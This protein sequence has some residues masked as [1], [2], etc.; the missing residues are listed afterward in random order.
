MSDK[1]AETDQSSRPEPEPV[2][3]QLRRR[4]EAALR[5]PRLKSGK[6]DPA[7]EVMW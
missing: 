7:S 3:V 6:R 5:M 1:P 4:R 2:A